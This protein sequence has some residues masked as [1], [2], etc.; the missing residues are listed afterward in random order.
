M[1][2]RTFSQHGLRPLVPLEGCI[3]ANEYKVILTDH[4]YHLYPIIKRFYPNGVFSSRMIMSFSTGHDSSLN[5]IM[6][7][8]MM[9]ILF[10]ALH[11]QEI[12][13]QLNIYGRFWTDIVDTL[14]PIINKPFEEISFGRLV[15][16]PPVEFHRSLNQGTLKLVAQGGPAP[17]TLHFVFLYF[18]TCL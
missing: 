2:G 14:H 15:F 4:L 7:V 1:L 13:T 10:Y 18:A 5:C 11:S 12:S 8:K 9:S 16:I 6:S 3:T 17:K